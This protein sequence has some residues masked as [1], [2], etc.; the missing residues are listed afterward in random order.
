MA[1][2]NIATFDIPPHMEEVMS[3]QINGPDRQFSLNDLVMQT[4]LQGGSEVDIEFLEHAMQ[5]SGWGRISHRPEWLPGISLD[6]NLWAQLDSYGRRII[7][8]DRFFM[9]FD[10]GAVLQGTYAIFQ[11]YSRRG[12][13]CPP[14]QGYPVIGTGKNDIG[15]GLYPNVPVEQLRNHRRVTTAYASKFLSQVP[16]AR[17]FHSGA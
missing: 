6:V 4:A 2:S 10:E 17:F 7:G 5:P 9:T 1:N 14:E 16:V 3:G 8:P 15:I 11:V 13:R 12:H